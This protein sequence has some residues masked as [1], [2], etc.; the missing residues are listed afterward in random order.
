MIHTHILW[1]IQLT[2]AFFFVFVF[3]YF[4]IEPT[5]GRQEVDPSAPSICAN[6]L[7]SIII[8]AVPSW[9]D[10]TN[11]KATSNN[12]ILYTCMTEKT[13]SEVKVKVL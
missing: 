8:G 3:W 10:G 11:E 2:L 9:N 1:S 7:E 4:G 6:P 13:Q 5:P 12:N